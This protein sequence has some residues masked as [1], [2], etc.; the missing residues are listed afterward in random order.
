M[1]T[2]ATGRRR[3]SPPLLAGAPSLPAGP[4]SVSGRRKMAVLGPRACFPG[5]G[6]GRTVLVRGL[7]P[8]ARAADLE[9]E[10]GQ[11]GPVRRAVA[12]T[13]P[14]GEACT[15]LGFVSFSLPEDAQR[16][17]REIRTFGGRRVSLAL[18]RPKRRRAAGGGGGAGERRRRGGGA[19]VPGRLR[20]PG[21]AFGGLPRA[22]SL[23][24]PPG[25]AFLPSFPR[26]GAPRGSPATAGAPQGP[27]PPQKGPA[28]RPQP[29]LQ[30][31]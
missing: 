22:A 6:M 25:A 23:P 17:L 19:R 11:A 27:D 24:H 31:R 14:G 26:G 12:V 18:A 13:A 28:D 2:R 1:R 30:G 7:P 8:S 21:A 3:S 10:F 20:S 4:P 9:R 29:Q 16:A 15:G 5:G